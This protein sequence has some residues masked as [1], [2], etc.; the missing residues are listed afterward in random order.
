[1]SDHYPLLIANIENSER[2]KV[3]VTAPFDGSEIATLDAANS[4]DAEKSLNTAHALYNDKSKW[5]TASQRLDV[6]NNTA[7]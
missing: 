5:L 1:M 4:N 3:T 2:D 6:L 7:A